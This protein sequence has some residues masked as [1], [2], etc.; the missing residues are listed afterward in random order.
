MTRSVAIDASRS[1]SG[2]AVAHVHGLL[3]GADPR[4]FGIGRVHLWGYEGLFR[5]LPE[6]SWLTCHVPDVAT[7]STVQQLLWQRYGLPNE[8]RA[9]GCSLVFNTDA[10]S[11]CP[12]RPGVTLSQDMLSFEPGEARRFGVSKARLRLFLL[13]HVQTRSLRRAEGAVFLTHYARSVI[14]QATGPLEHS[15]VI[16]HGVGEEFRSEREPGSRRQGPGAELRLVY[17]SNASYYKHQ[18]NVIRAVKR[19]R[20]EGHAVQLLLVGGGRGGPQRRLEDELRRSDPCREFVE[21]REFV[22]HDKIPG[23]LGAQDVFVF[24]S[25]CENMPITL[26]EGMA[27]GLPIACSSRGP[28]PEVLGDAGLY[29]D[30]EDVSSIAESLRVLLQDKSLRERLGGIA[31]ERARRF[32]WRRCAEETWSFLARAIEEHETRSP[33]AR[34]MGADEPAAP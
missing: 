9:A 34:G 4:D 15:A 2:G 22:P 27:A 25:S 3:T 16:N 7:K 18:W 20:T 33:T 21:Q 24:A 8:I 26:I 28:M 6:L 1:K 13:R 10:G 5:A 11:V 31:R 12:F 32:T 19:L 17:V 23:I 30:P 29:F 14:E